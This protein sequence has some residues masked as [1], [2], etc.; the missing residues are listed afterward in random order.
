MALVID[1]KP[2]EKILVGSTVITND[3]Q[4]TRLR[5][6]GDAPI[7]REKDTMNLEDATTHAKKLYFT[8]QSMYVA[9]SDRA[10]D[11]L[12]NYADYLKNIRSLAP[13]IS[14]FLND[15]SMEVLQGTYYKALKLVQDL[16]MAEEGGKEPRANNT[17]TNAPEKFNQAF[18]EAQLLIQSAEQLQSLYN[19]WD[20]HDKDSIESIISY[21]RKLWMVFFDGVNDQNGKN[22]TK[23]K[24]N[25]DITSNI[26]NLYNYI[27]KR[28]A[29]ILSTNDKE[30]LKTLIFINQEAATALRRG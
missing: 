30:K 2:N 15:I 7:L 21:N 22:N 6:D 19:E 28:S 9:N 20:T 14:D 27:Y 24:D 25:F 13:H 23:N 8:I 16:I 12:D 5:I 17:D 10:M 29:D 11:E 3:K 4:R 26:I 18:M 1:L